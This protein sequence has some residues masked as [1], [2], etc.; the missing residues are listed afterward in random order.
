MHAQQYLLPVAWEGS[1]SS[2]LIWL[3]ASGAPLTTQRLRRGHIRM[4]A[5]RS[6]TRGPAELTLAMLVMICSAED[7]SREH[8]RGVRRSII[9]FL[10]W[11]QREKL[12]PA[13]VGN[14]LPRVP[15]GPPNPRPYPDRLWRQ[16]LVVAGGRERMMIRLA[17]EMG[18]RRAEVAVCR[19]E[20]LTEDL[21]GYHL[22]IHGKGGK[23]RLV[24][25]PDKL[26]EDFMDFCP[27]G[28]LFP[29]NDNGHLSPMAVGKLV[30][31]LMPQGWS[32]HKLRHRFASRSL[33]RTDDLLT[34]RDAL[35][36]TSVATT[37]IYTKPAEGKLR[38]LME[39]AADD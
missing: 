37:Q 23:Q 4:V 9:S 34:L 1:I 24:P 31:D 10:E 38:R 27:G 35:G 12:V 26:A 30:A 3:S 17:G 22:L 7:W 19:R 36:H 29:G 20:D 21:T 28:Y 25:M 33:S 13:N 32:M 11:A 8:R 6:S 18:M 16:L 15:S 2:W 39:A 14:G 5:H